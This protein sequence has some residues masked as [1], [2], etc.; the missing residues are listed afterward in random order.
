MVTQHGGECGTIFFFGL[1]AKGLRRRVSR[2]NLNETRPAVTAVIMGGSL[3]FTF[4]FTRIVL[5][6]F[7]WQT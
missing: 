1:A 7:L 6:A 5:M 2:S 4:T 3:F